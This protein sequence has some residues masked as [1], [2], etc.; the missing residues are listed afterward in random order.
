MGLSFFVFLL[1]ILMAV[2]YMYINSTQNT[3]IDIYNLYDYN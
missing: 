2:K 1:T 3:L